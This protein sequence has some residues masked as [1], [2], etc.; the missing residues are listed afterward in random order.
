MCQKRGQ[1]EDINWVAKELK[2]L[3]R[4][5]KM[6]VKESSKSINIS[7]EEIKGDQVS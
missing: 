5:K 6:P 7:P 1:T 3:L 2:E 4:P